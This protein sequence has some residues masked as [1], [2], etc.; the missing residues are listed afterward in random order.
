MTVV[1]VQNGNGQHYQTLTIP[2]QEQVRLWTLA[3]FC[4]G[5]M[6]FGLPKFAVVSLLT[7]LLNPS[8]LHL[9]LLWGMTVLCL[10]TLVAT[11][12][13]LLGQC[14]PTRAMWNFD[15]AKTCVDP[16]YIVNFSLFAGAL[17]A[18][19]DLYLAIYPAVV[20]FQL[21]MKLRK[22]LALTAALGIGCVGAA[23]AIYKTTRIPSGLYSPD[24]S[25]DSSD[26]INWTII[27]GS[28]IIIAATI[29][30]LSPLMDKIFRG[31][32]PFSSSRKTD[33]AH[34]R[35]QQYYGERSA[36][37]PKSGT[38]PS[39]DSAKPRRPLDPLDPGMEL[40]ETIIIL[41]SSE[42]ALSPRREKQFDDLESQES[43]TP[44][45]RGRASTEKSPVEV[46]GEALQK[47]TSQNGGR[48]L[49][50]NEVTVTVTYNT[51]DEARDH[52]ERNI[53]WETQARADHWPLR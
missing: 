12:G 31:R 44:V 4:P 16:K 17:S 39:L 36:T 21:Q 47:S 9:W 22:K 15:M 26:L 30:I 51:R 18:F 13:T 3:A 27:E 20:L 28:T 8:R 43:T 14:T 24:F 52:V 23:V 38:L 1:A 33:S 25:Y 35:R 41:N 40:Q 7:R 6:C 42:E 45:T 5:V 53:P 2:Q 37:G 34:K 46:V 19:V 50:T 10:L 11:V 29:P 49:R 32:N 48:I